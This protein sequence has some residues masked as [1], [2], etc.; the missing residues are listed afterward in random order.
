MSDANLNFVLFWIS[1]VISVIQ[2]IFGTFGN[3]FNIIIFTRRTLRSNPCSTYF[4]AASVS[5]LFEIYTV[6][7][8]NYFGINWN[9]FPSN[10]NDAWCRISHFLIYSFVPLVL[11]FIVLVSFD[12]FLTSSLNAN[13]RKISTL[14]L[15]RK[16]TVST[17]ILSFVMFGHLA[18]LVK[19]IK[20]D[21]DSYCTVRSSTYT[22]FYNVMFVIVGN[23]LPVV[24]MAFFAILTVLNMG[25]VRSR[26]T[27]KVNNMP[28]QRLRSRDHQFMRMLLF[29]VLTTILIS[30]P[31]CC[32]SMYN[33]FA[34]ILLEQ[35]LS[36]SETEIINFT[37]NF[38]GILYYTN[39]VTGFYVYTLTGHKFRVE[40]KVCIKHG[41]S[42]IST[43]ICLPLKTQQFISKHQRGNH[44]RPVQQRP[45]VI[46][47]TV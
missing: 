11:W 18:F 35:Q 29:Q 28:N 22:I 40:F 34:R 39:S 42:V 37:A 17:M 6:I 10:T 33:T 12:R 14:S 25:K 1:H 38:L 45:A 8:F 46:T 32:V 7:L 13:T 47:T 27:P 36:P 15:A 3:F 26:V 20:V 19:S 4:L 41:L 24:L 31:F 5:N 9:W 43:V 44:V 21:N 2:I 16:M 30:I 23:V